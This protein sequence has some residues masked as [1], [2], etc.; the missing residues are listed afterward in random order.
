MLNWLR[1]LGAS[2]HRLVVGSGALAEAAYRVP[3]VAQDRG[4]PPPSA[5]VNS[6]LPRARSSVTSRCA[7]GDR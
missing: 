1:G 7:A 5:D 6:R 4:A 2:I 3:P